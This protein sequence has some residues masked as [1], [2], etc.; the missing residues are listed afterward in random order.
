MV[1]SS[2]FRVRTGL[3]WNLALQLS[4]LG[5]LK[6]MTYSLGVTFFLPEY[7]DEKNF[8]LRYEKQMR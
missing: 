6:Q 7:E 3:C 8:D 5:N 4:S 1:M 2:S